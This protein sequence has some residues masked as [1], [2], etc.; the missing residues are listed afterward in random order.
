MRGKRRG[1]T[2]AISRRKMGHMFQLFFPRSAFVR[3]GAA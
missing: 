2:A 1:L 3:F